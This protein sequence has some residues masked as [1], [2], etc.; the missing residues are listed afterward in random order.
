MAARIEVVARLHRE[1]VSELAVMRRRLIDAV[2]RAER[3]EADRDRLVVR[4]AAAEMVCVAHGDEDA[5]FVPEYASMPDSGSCHCP[6]HLAWRA[7]VTS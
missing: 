5:V 7:T 3:A 1:L 6:E 2:D 4:L